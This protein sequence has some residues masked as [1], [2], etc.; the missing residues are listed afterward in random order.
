[1]MI[2]QNSN[3]SFPSNADLLKLPYLCTHS[4]DR[5]LLGCSVHYEVSPIHIRLYLLSHWVYHSLWIVCHYLPSILVLAYNSLQ[6]VDQNVD[7]DVFA[8]LDQMDPTF[9]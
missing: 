7:K 4:W 5:P 2:S 1:M 3:E 9:S 8:L 6:Q